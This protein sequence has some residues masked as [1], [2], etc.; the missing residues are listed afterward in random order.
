MRLNMSLLFMANGWLKRLYRQGPYFQKLSQELFENHT[1]SRE[2]LER[3]QLERLQKMIH[4]CY[5]NVPYYTD[6][7]NRLGL[8]HND[9]QTLQDLRKI[10]VLDKHI[11]KAN[12]EKLIAKNIPKVFCKTAHTSG[13]TGMPSTF[14]RDYHSMKM[15][16]SGGIGNRREIMAKNG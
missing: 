14:L 16:S 6:L 13:T 7:F 8:K 1:F 12:Y 9:F 15:P 3:Y 2:M 10:P 4:Y 5:D 11:V